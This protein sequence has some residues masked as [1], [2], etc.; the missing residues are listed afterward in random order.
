MKGLEWLEKSI[1][2][3]PKLLDALKKQKDAD[4]ASFKKRIK[5]EL[6]KDVNEM[7]ENVRKHISTIGD[8]LINR[9]TKNTKE[10]SDDGI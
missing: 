9:K 4:H 6:E 5:E 3:N 8:M 1:E 2:N 7:D 10:S